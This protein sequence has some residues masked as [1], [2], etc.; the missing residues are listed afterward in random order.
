ME[1]ILYFLIVLSILIK[2]F[3]AYDCGTAIESNITKKQHF[4][5]IAEIYSTSKTKDGRFKHLC[6]SSIIHLKFAVTAAHCIQEKDSSY[7][8]SPQEVFLLSNVLDLKDLSK[9]IKI[10]IQ[11]IFTHPSWNPDEEKFDGDIA[12]LEFVEVLNFSEIVSPICLWYENTEYVK[13]ESIKSGKIISFVALE[14]DDP[15]YYNHQHDENHNFPKEYIMP[16]RENCT[17]TQKRFTSI[18]SENSFCAG[19][20]NSGPCLETGSSGSSMAVELNDK[21]Y[22]RGIVSASFIDFAGCDNYTF[23][24]FT[25]VL[26]Y[27]IWIQEVINK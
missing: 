4:P 10:E 21:F 26:K 12:L 15:G 11:N 3:S 2:K 18:A 20:L 24:L 19:G 17:A 7:A 6:S 5:W 22:L 8:R 9:A 27:Q 14:E 16:V 13:I 23:T 1:K 25:D